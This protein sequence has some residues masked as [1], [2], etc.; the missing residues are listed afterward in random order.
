MNEAA[1]RAE[2]GRL[3]PVDVCAELIA[4]AVVEHS[5][6]PG[7]HITIRIDGHRAE[8]TDTGRGMRMTPDASDTI[9]HAE[10]ALT[11]CYP[12][13]PAS[14]DVAAAL[15]DLVWGDRGSLG[16]ALPNL[17]CPSL[18]FDSSRDGEVWSQAFRYGEPAGP[19]TFLGLTARTGTTIDLETAAAIDA[20]AVGGLI[21]EL[22]RRLPGLSIRLA[23]PE[24]GPAADPRGLLRTLG[25]GEVAHPGQ[26]LLDHLVGTFDEL[27][28]L[29]VR[30]AE[31]VAGLCHAVYGTAG[32]ADAPLSWSERPRLAAAIGPRAERL[33]FLYS[34]SDQDDFVARAGPDHRCIVDRRTGDALALEADEFAGLLAIWLGNEL[35]LLNSASTAFLLDGGPGVWAMLER[36]RDH[37]PDGGVDELVR[38]VERVR[39]R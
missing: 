12:C 28:G 23:G 22:G 18:V 8:I 39:R 26:T 34:I 27:R 35:E 7:L 33:V 20:A 17:A 11:S 2:A 19:P 15:H 13:E 38:R 31:C 21:A 30:E 29:G 4:L 6:T 1:L 14:P 9:S 25:V 24:R 10:R 36:N 3:T 32:F 16:P 37:L 5:H